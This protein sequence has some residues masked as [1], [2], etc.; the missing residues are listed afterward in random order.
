MSEQLAGEQAR[1]GDIIEITWDKDGWLGK[2]LTVVEPPP[3][4]SFYNS[5]SDAWFRKES[6]ELKFF[7]M[8]YYK[9]VEKNAT[10]P[11]R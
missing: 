2:R 9:I 4:V 11:E 3:D 10:A 6:G 7:G 1:P 8:A 5:P